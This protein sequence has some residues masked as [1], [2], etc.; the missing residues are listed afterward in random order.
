MNIDRIP[1]RTSSTRYLIAGIIAGT[2]ALIS[3]L[4]YVLYL[5]RRWN[6]TYGAYM[7]LKE[8]VG[9]QPGIEP[10]R[11]LFGSCQ[12]HSAGGGGKVSHHLHYGGR[13]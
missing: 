2:L 1:R 8:H 3:S 5:Q 7:K 11:L 10:V 6:E 12:L 4:L 9:P 13:S